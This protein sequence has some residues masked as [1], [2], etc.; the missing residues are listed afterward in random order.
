MAYYSPL[1]D[2]NK[3][4]G[5]TAAA[6]PRR[7][8]CRDDADRQNIGEAGAQPCCPLRLLIH[9]IGKSMKIAVLGATGATGGVFLRIAL[10]AGH[11]ISA[12][13]RDAS[14]L[15]AHKESKQMEIIIGNALSEQDVTQ[16][17]AGAD[18]GPMMR[19]ALLT[20]VC[21]R[22]PALTVGQRS[23]P[24]CNDS[25]GLLPGP[26]PRRPVPNDVHCL[27]K[28]HER[29]GEARCPSTVR[30]HDYYRY[31]H[32]PWE[33]ARDPHKQ[34]VVPTCHMRSHALVL[35]SCFT[36][37]SGVGGTSAFVKCFLGVFLAGIKVISDY[38][39]ADRIVRESTSNV[40]FVLVR[41]GHLLDGPATGKYKVSHKGFYHAAMQIT[42]A[43]VAMFLLHAATTD[44]YDK[45]AVQ[46][47]T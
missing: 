39:K 43:D 9:Q 27:F 26:R 44:K 18:G 19:L 42:R 14:K 10:D 34:V 23:S 21:C 22:V 24:A 40:P 31:G 2:C 1:Q 13:V 33:L 41:P 35:V 5:H 47:F 20:L 30:P 29:C 25:G 4:Q 7:G 11:Q 6:R 36:F 28:H 32:S 46:L 38:E 17:V 8:F 16:V 15:A 45:Q 12:L 37:C 3:L